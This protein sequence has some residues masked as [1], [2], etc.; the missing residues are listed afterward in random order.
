MA[1]AASAT[2]PFPSSAKAASTATDVGKLSVPTAV[3]N[4]PG[5]LTDEE[6]EVIRGHPGS[7]SELLS[8]IEFLGPAID[9]IRYHHERVDGRGYPFGIVG[10]ELPM[11]AKIVTACDAFDAMTSTRSYRFAMDVD[12][13]LKELSR[14]AGT[15]FDAG[16]V[17]VLQRVVARLDWQPVIDPVGDSADPHPCAPHV[18]EH[19]IELES[20]RSPLPLGMPGTVG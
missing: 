17:E 5:G 12:E 1:T 2:G 16:V 15:Q 7:G 8:G 9:G 18:H 6:F 20:Q 10:D 3:L 14:C 19:V 4:K 13:A 11:V